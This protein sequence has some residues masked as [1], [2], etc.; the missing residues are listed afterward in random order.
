MGLYN[1]GDADVE[2]ANITLDSDGVVFDVGSRIGIIGPGEIVV[3]CPTM[4]VLTYSKY[5]CDLALGLVF[6][7]STVATLYDGGVAVDSVNVQ[8]AAYATS[9]SATAY[10]LERTPCGS[11][12]TCS[13][14]VSRGGSSSW[15]TLPPTTTSLRCR[16]GVH[17]L[18][19][20]CGI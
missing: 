7:P 19:P 2:T 13:S 3:L 5:P 4:N 9:Q 14:M 18:L 12:V 16:T 6:G 10:A 8:L 20:D 17:S 11:R 15:V 1:P